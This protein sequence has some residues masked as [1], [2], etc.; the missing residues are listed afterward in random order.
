MED[1]GGDGF[2]NEVALVPPLRRV[3]TV[4]ARGCDGWDED[5]LWLLFHGGSDD[6]ATKTQEKV[7][8]NNAHAKK[9]SERVI[10]IVLLTTMVQ[11]KVL[12]EEEWFKITI[13]PLSKN[14]QR[15]TECRDV[16][17]DRW[18]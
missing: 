8:E 15:E 5:C 4:D 17:C 16:I 10:A 18:R 1:L 2:E 13:D 7:V 3:R 14:I 6:E 9:N 12:I 11:A